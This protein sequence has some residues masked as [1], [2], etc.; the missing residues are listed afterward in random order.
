[1]RDRTEQI[2]ASI[3]GALFLIGIL[4]ILIILAWKEHSE[5]EECRDRGG[6]VE[7][8]NFRTIYVPQSC[9][10]NCTI[11]VPQE[12]SDWRCSGIKAERE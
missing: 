12:V 4:V 2:L 9:G 5:Q 1:M 11:M 3:G 8:Y 6:Y 10:S 7:R